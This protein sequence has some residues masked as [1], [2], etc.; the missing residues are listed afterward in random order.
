MIKIYDFTSL[1][2]SYLSSAFQFAGI[3]SGILCSMILTRK[4][5]KSFKPAS[6]IIIAA[7]VI[8]KFDQIHKSLFLAFFIVFFAIKSRSFAWLML[9][10]I[11][12][13]FFNLA[14]YSVA[15]EMPLYQARE[16]KGIGEAT[17]C[18][19]V[20]MT[21]NLIGFVVVLILTPILEG[22]SL[23][24]SFGVLSIVLILGEVLMCLVKL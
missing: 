7:T 3:F 1:Q 10:V 14:Q 22:K 18:G 13:G 11:I 8:C 6:L 17:I 4:G 2:A 20:N 15:Y 23:L 24:L 19:C 12:N 21:A 5:P 16:N 9:A